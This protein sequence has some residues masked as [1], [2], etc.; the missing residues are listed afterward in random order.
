MAENLAEYKASLSSEEIQSL[1]DDTAEMIAFSTEEAPPEMIR[2]LQAVTVQTLPEEV[3]DYAIQD[4]IRD[5]VRYVTAPTQ[6]GDVGLTQIAL[7][8]SWVPAEDLGIL[9]LYTNLA[10]ALDTTEHT[11]EELALLDTRFLNGL[12]V[13]P[14]LMEEP[15]EHYRPVLSAQWT[16][17]M[18]DYAT[19]IGLV[20]EILFQTKFDNV[21]DIQ[22]II[23]RIKTATLQDLASNAYRFQY[24]RVDAAFSD[25][26]AYQNYTDGVDAY[27][28]LLD[29]EKQ[30][31]KEPEQILQSLQDMQAALY[32]KANAVTVFAGNAAAV[33][34]FHTAIP[35]FFV[36][37][38]DATREPADYSS[39]PRP[40]MREALAVES[41]VQYNLVYAPLEVLGIENNGLLDPLALVLDD[42]Y[43]TPNLRHGLGAYGTFSYMDRDGLLVG[44]YRDPS[45]AETYEVL[46]G[47]G[48][49]LE[50]LDMAQEDLDRYII[51]AY[52]SYAT[53]T[54][55]LNGAA[56]AI[57]RH[58][59][60][61]STDEKLTHMRQMKAVT[62]ED[63]H[64]MAPVL[65]TLYTEGM[66]STSGGTA[67]IEANQNL[68]EEV[69]RVE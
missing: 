6:A 57:A 14:S 38:A 20:H 48:A 2:S 8:T 30:L 35:P 17:L 46:S 53:P 68:F 45:I 39:L 5:G 44:S 42:G 28:A 67:M 13:S 9:T 64:N 59:A 25:K 23:T 66:H 4:E 50:G 21:A 60:G 15:G 52:S 65:D 40:A 63:L 37:M 18:D 62:V 33:E 36:S 58:L 3:D 69:L 47:M 56:E 34:T 16:S 49:Y 43:L 41:Q 55:N 61:R 19:G 54:G 1:V 26:G 51:K 10:G 7:D 31:Q 22:A 27:Y 32:N 29:I 12:S 24:Y 11:K